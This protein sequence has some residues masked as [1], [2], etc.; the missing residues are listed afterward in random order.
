MP[1]KFDEQLTLN[2]NDMCELIK[3]AIA[4]NNINGTCINR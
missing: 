3:T 1:T 4:V 2:V